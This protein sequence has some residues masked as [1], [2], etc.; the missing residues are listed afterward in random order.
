[1]RGLLL[2]KDLRQKAIDGIMT[3]HRGVIKNMPKEW[4]RGYG[5]FENN[6]HGDEEFI[7]HGECGTKVIY[8]PYRVGD[9]L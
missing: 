4:H 1:M 5:A 2:I 9:H 6:P 8:A 7:I 3:Q